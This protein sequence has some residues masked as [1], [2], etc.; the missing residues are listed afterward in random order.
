MPLLKNNVHF[1][2][3]RG[4]EHMLSWLEVYKFQWFVFEGGRRSSK[5]NYISWLL[6]CL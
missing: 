1:S 6:C 3:T 5:F 2:F 4:L